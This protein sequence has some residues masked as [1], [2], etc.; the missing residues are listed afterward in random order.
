MTY[1]TGQSD[2]VFSPMLKVPRVNNPGVYGALAGNF[3]NIDDF[4]SFYRSFSDAWGNDL[5]LLKSSVDGLLSGNNPSIHKFLRIGTHAVAPQDEA[6][7]TEFLNY[8]NTASKDK[9]FVGSTR[10]VME[11]KKIASLVNKSETIANDKLIIQ[12]HTE[13]IPPSFRYRNLTMLVKSADSMV[14]VKY[15]GIPVP[16]NR[17][18]KQINLDIIQGSKNGSFTSNTIYRE[19]VAYFWR[20]LSGPDSLLIENR[21][22]AIAS[23]SNFKVTGTYTFELTVTDEN[24]ST[25]TDLVSIKCFPPGNQAPKANA[26]EDISINLPEISIYPDGSASTDLD[27]T[28]KSYLWKQINGPVT[29]SI[30]NSTSAH[31]KIT[32]LTIA[33][34]YSFLLTVTD[35]KNAI[36]IDTLVVIVKPVL[37]KSPVAKAGNDS[38]ILMPAS[39]ILL[40]GNG[41]Y[42]PDGKISSYKWTKISGPSVKITDGTKSTPRIDNMIAPGNYTFELKVSDL[43]GAFSTDTIS[44]MVIPQNPLKIYPVANAGADIF[45]APPTSSS[46]LK[47]N[48]LAEQSSTIKSY[49]WTQIKGPVTALVVNS[50]ASSTGVSGLT[51][52]GEYSFE[53]IVTD[54]RGRSNADTVSIWVLEQPNRIPSANAGED[55]SIPLNEP[56]VKLSALQ[57]NDSDGTIKTFLW[58]Q[59]SGPLTAK[60]ENFQNPEIFIRELNLVGTYVFQ[61]KV[62][63]NMGSSS[64]D[65]VSIFVKAPANLAPISNAGGDIFVN[66][67]VNQIYLYGT[68]SYDTDG[69]ISSYR[70]LRLSG[71]PVKMYDSTQAI[72]RLEKMTN[73][74]VYVFE[75]K[76][77]DNKGAFSRDTIWV[78]VLDQVNYS[79]SIAQTQS[80]IFKI[81]EIS[82]KRDTLDAIKVWPNPVA[83][84]LNVAIHGKEKDK[85]DYYL[86]SSNGRLL[87]HNSLINDAK[88]S[89]FTVMVS[90][91]QAGQYIFQI[92]GPNNQTATFILIKL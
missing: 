32:Q 88:K 72:T 84:R 7:F 6:A 74:G 38:S 51:S 65:L 86:Y 18:T 30:E 66:K 79:G 78:N 27:G 26:G 23:I 91:L 15:N 68:S 92:S 83:D 42:D 60:I 80:P 40:L 54:S 52:S 82:R 46:I 1:V 71:P 55:I 11:H 70:W 56:Q 17:I 35:N 34:T 59:T 62:T 29:P 31:P 45:I 25:S 43:K 39:N 41:S 3:E 58:T 28:I 10:E 73:T 57:S 12:L 69:K 14:S 20:Q 8:V 22:S 19:P 9:L 85:F 37:N 81:A 16:F 75:L 21:D 13:N 61:V 36:S 64:T 87:K 63:D 77:T 2:Q 50:K 67:P 48:A 24:G 5:S 89:V 33:G 90:E 4:G 49:S 53:A 44:I 76:V 47:V